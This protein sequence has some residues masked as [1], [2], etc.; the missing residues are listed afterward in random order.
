ML[1]LLSQFW[2]FLCQQ[3]KW[4]LLPIIIVLLVLGAL[5]L[6]SQNSPLS[7]FMYDNQR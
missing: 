3:K 1:R 6:F 5:L 7:P 4:W 2:G